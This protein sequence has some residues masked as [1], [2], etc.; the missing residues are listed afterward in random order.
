MTELQVRDAHGNVAAAISAV[1]TV[2]QIGSNEFGMLAEQLLIVAKDI[3][4]GVY[5]KSR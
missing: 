1:G 4:S 5:K 3:E 2:L